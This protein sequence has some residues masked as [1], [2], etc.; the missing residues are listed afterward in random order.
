MVARPMGGAA[1]S[2]VIEFWCEMCGGH[3]IAEGLADVAPV[4]RNH[5]ATCP[6]LDVVPFIPQTGQRVAD[7]DTPG[8]RL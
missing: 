2:H 6:A 8:G 3:L 1:V 4:E 5:L 7:V